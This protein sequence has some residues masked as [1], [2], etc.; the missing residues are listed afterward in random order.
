MSDILVLCNQQLTPFGLL[1]A[2]QLLA[3]PE[4]TIE[5]SHAHLQIPAR[6]YSVYFL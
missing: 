3:S 5:F 2:F 4:S 1:D 6:I